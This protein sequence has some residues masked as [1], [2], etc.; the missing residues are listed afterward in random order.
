MKWK[1]ILE[2]ELLKPGN[3]KTDRI[4]AGRTEHYLILDIW[5]K[6]Q[7][8]CRHAMQT[9]SGEYGTYYCDTKQK[10]GENLNT[11]ADE[12]EWYWGADI[13]DKDWHLQ[14]QDI[15]IIKEC[16]TK[17][18][19][20]GTLSRV[21][22]MEEDY[23]REKREMAGLRKE[24]RLKDL[25][26]LCPEPGKAVKDWIVEKAVGSLQYAFYDKTQKIYHC[27]ACQGDIRETKDFKPKDRAEVSCPLCGHPVTVSRRKAA[28]TLKTRLTMIQNMDEKR[29]VERHFDVEI[30]WEKK[31]TVYLEEQIRLTMLRVIK[32]NSC[33]IYYD[34][35]WGGWSEG[36]RTGRRWKASYL[37]PDREGIRAGLAGT[38]YEEWSEVLPMLAE[39]GI[40]ANYNGLLVESNRYWTAI[41]EYLAKGRFY[42][43][44]EELSEDI[45]YWGGYVFHLVNQQGMDIGEVLQL[46]DR[47]LINR[48]RQENGGKTMLS[49]L[50]WS[51]EAGKKISSQTVC[52]MEKNGISRDTYEQSRAKD[53]FSPEQL[54]NYITRQQAESYTRQKAYTIF[55]QYEDYISMAELLGKKTEDALV[56]RPKDLKLRHAEAN[57][58][59]E[60]RQEEIR[61]NRD[62]ALARKQA[63]DMRKKYPGYEELLEEIRKKYEYE[64]EAYL[65]RVPKDFMEITAEG[66]A[67]HHCV[68]NTERYFDRIVSRETYICFLRQQS[69]PDTP[70][71]TIEVEPGGTI[72]QH[73]G[74]YDEEPEIEKIKPFLREWQKEI[75]KRMTHKDHEYAAKSVILRQKNIEELEQ[76]NNTRVLN[77]LMEDLMEAI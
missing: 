29:G 57:K 47:Q 76:K 73:R 74:A 67:L 51:E 14:E 50:Q 70:F 46:K 40:K 23:G 62:A 39:M 27:T 58:E 52:W 30:T 18:W 59:M 71:Y 63:E 38:A 68:G 17:G 48:L 77:G 28:R 35:N 66:M 5:K 43:L 26:A 53:H 15:Q 16:T 56:Y 8:K 12:H 13:K 36:N 22:G 33:K 44:L 45:T 20:A 9:D 75:K 2:A 25:M 42:R 69:S 61:R 24:Q 37:Y 34:D 60:L 72:R 7:R 4:V 55:N 1:E 54:M 21:T 19:R 65:I 49:W 32:K 3:K 41:A 10:T 64:S 6:G 11:A 31:R